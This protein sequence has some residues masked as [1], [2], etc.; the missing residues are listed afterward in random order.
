MQ[1]HFLSYLFLHMPAD[2]QKSHASGTHKKTG[3]LPTLRFYAGFPSW[4]SHPNLIH[5]SH[6]NLSHFILPIYS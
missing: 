1:Y 2:K 5:C 3:R 4:C 6:P